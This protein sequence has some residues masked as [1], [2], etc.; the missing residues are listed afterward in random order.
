M[1][2][3]RQRYLGD[4]RT[5]LQQPQMQYRCNVF[6]GRS[7]RVVAESGRYDGGVADRP[8]VHLSAAEPANVRTFV[9]TADDNGIRIRDG[10]N[11]VII[12]I[13]MLL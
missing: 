2:R 3:R 7:A 11:I 8:L 1:T 6:S 13:I 9:D 12:T 4:C 5:Y 10:K